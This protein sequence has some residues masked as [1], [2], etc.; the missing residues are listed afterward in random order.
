MAFLR[1]QRDP[2]AQLLKSNRD[3]RSVLIPAIAGAV[4]GMIGVGAAIYFAMP[5]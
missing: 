5:G 3:V 1:D 4:A 2:V